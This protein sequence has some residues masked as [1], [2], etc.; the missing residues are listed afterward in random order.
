VNRC[1]ECEECMFLCSGLMSGIVFVMIVRVCLKGFFCLSDVCVV[2]YCRTTKM[3]ARDR[4]MY[5]RCEHVTTTKHINKQYMIKQIKKINMKIIKH[6]LANLICPFSIIMFEGLSSTSNM[7]ADD[8]FG[9]AVAVDG[10]LS[11]VSPGML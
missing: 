7:Y 2:N 9:V 11:C 6:I 4:F 3:I 8:P 1:S 5:M 10:V